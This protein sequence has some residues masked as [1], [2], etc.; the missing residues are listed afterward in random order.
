MVPALKGLAVGVLLLAG[1][2]LPPLLQLRDIPHTRLLRRESAPPQARTVMTYALGLLMFGALLVWQ[3]GDPVTGLLMALAFIAGLLVFGAVAWAA[4]A[5]LRFV[6]RSVDRGVLRLALADMRRRPAATVTQV[7]ALAL[8]LMALL[9]MTVVRGDLLDAWKNT[10]PANAPNH[11][12][13]NVQPEQLDVIGAR[14]A[15]YGKP[16]L[17]PLMRARL[18]HHNGRPA[19]AVDAGDKLAKRLIEHELDV[20][21]APSLPL[22]NTLVAGRW[23]G[24]A[25]GMPELSVSDMSA[26]ALGIKLGD[27]LTLEFGGSPLTAV[28]TSLRKVDWRSRH[29]NFGMLLNP[30]AAQGLAAT[31]A[32]SLFVPPADSAFV[33]RLVDDYPTLTVINTGAMVAQFQRML[34]QVSGAIEFLFLFTLA[35]GLLVL[36]ATLVSSQ[37][38]RQRQA[39]IL[40]ALGASRAQLSRALWI[41]YA[42]TGSLAGLLA[43][44][45]ASAGS[46]ALARFAFK[47][48]WQLSP[49]LWAAGLAAGAACALLG[50]WAG[51]RAVLNQA[52][53]Q[54]LRT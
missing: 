2:G 3:A 48:E 4:V 37:D 39:A 15:P 36:Y 42:L 11:I 18:L 51:L 32:T 22:S 46:W 40:R 47:L 27:R 7:V 44:G 53:L 16:V 38:E 50:G 54:S 12:I 23:F 52:P 21:S 14:L 26:K 30:A 49:A 31:Y 19:K 6:P 9:L 24:H 34:G 8:G 20:S 29:P 33:N 13:Y 43:A 28:V 41:E 10:A 25:N 5:A 45:G 35:S 1:F 17:H